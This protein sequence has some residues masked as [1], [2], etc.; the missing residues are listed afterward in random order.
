MNTYIDT[1]YAVHHVIRDRI[2]EYISFG[3]GIIHIKS[4]KQQ[5]NVNISI[6]FEWV[7][8]SGYIPYSLWIGYFFRATR[9]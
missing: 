3:N 4:S 7:R 1:N 9:L 8:L 6:E 5:I 2:G